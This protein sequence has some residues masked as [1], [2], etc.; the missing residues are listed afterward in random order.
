MFRRHS[1]TRSQKISA[2][3]QTYKY[4]PRERNVIYH[5]FRLIPC[6]SRVCNANDIIPEFI[7]STLGDGPSGN[8]GGRL[9]VAPGQEAQEFGARQLHPGQ[10]EEPLQ[11]ERR[12][13]GVAPRTGLGG[14]PHNTHEGGMWTSRPTGIG[15]ISS[16]LQGGRRNVQG[17]A[18]SLLLR[19]SFCFPERCIKS[20]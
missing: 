14:R 18:D 17:G 3:I 19:A 10:G 9:I 5:S 11:G 12:H 6:W 20:N 7:V 2:S 8:S 15:S 4:S 16:M 13:A 1:N